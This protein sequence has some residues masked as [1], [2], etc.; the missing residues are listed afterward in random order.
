M[1][2][3]SAA[4]FCRLLPA[5]PLVTIADYS[6]ADQKL[7]GNLDLYCQNL[8]K[9]QGKDGRIVPFAWNAAQQQLH[10]ALEKQLDRAGWV[11]AI[12]LK[13]RKVGISTYIGARYYQKTT[14]RLGQRSYILTHKDDATDT[15][16][17]MVKLMHDRMPLDYR[18]RLAKS[19]A[20][21]IEFA[22][23]H[24]G[25]RVS[26][27]GSMIGTGRSMTINYFHGSEVAFWP[28]AEK[29]FSGALETV[30]KIRDTEVILESTANGIGGVFYDQWSL[31]EKGESDFIPIFL[32]WFIDPE[33][34]QALPLGY[35]PSLEE[36]DY[37]ETYGLDEEQLCWAHFKNIALLGEPGKLGPIFHQEQPATAADAFQT[38]GAASFIPAERIR[39]A[40]RWQCPEQIREITRVLGVEVDR[41]GKDHVCIIDRKGRKMGGLVYEMRK[42][43]DIVATADRLCYLLSKHPDI[44]RAYIDTTEGA[45]GGIYDILKSRGDGDRIAAINLGASASDKNRYV[46]KRAEMYARL[47]PWLRDPAGASIPDDDALHKELAAPAFGGAGGCRHHANR[48]LQIQLNEHIIERLKFSPD[49]ADAAVLPFAESIASPTGPPLP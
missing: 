3:E 10:A 7:F 18:H 6:A 31:A 30:P 24:G 8:V 1:G 9:I 4:G 39:R 33:N 44:A 2:A 43:G 21:E 16:F 25:Y 14:T 22:G 11:R 29:Q 17:A 34:R 40:R 28:Q 45:G 38:S 42:D 41:L 37:A 15:L 46:N 48:R 35:E 19:N 26:T 49:R 36:Q 32:P 12:V 47:K 23:T 13:A 5:V 27:A 20:G